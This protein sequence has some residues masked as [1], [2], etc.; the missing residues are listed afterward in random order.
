MMAYTVGRTLRKTSSL[1]SVS[2]I[3][4]IKSFISTVLFSQIVYF[5]LEAT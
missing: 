5:S 1:D 4:L 2:N 3:L